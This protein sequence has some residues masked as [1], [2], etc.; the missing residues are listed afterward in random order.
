MI[1]QLIYNAGIALYSAAIALASPFH[2]KAALLRAGRRNTFDYLQ[3]HLQ[4]G[5]KYL[6]FHTASLG[7]FEQGRPVMEALKERHPEARI[8][9]TFFS[10]SGYEIRKNYAGADLV[11][12]LPA[13]T[14]ANAR[15]L[16]DVIPVKA[17]VFIKYEFW[18]NYLTELNRR[19]IPTYSIAAIFR[20]EQVFFKS[21]GKWYRKVLSQFHKIFV[22][23]DA[24]LQLLKKINIAKA[25]IAGDTRFDRVQAVAATARRFP[26]IEEFIGDCRKVIIAGSS[27]PQDEELLVRYL[28]EHSDTKL[29]LVPHEIHENHLDGITKQVPDSRRY[30][31]LK[32]GEFAGI[33][34]LVIDTIGM[35]SSVYQYAS[36]AY[37]GG[38]FGVGIHNTLEAAVWNV[39]V[40]FGPN[41]QKFR[42]ARELIAVGGGFSINGYDALQKC[43]NHLLDEAAG[44]QRSYTIAKNGAGNTANIS[45]SG[46]KAGDYV[47]A[48]TGATSIIINQLTNDIY[49]KTI[50]P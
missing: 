31:Q 17:A 24:S 45:A 8:L 15:R 9:L 28:N 41:N 19:R 43:F 7:E 50:H 10:P 34:C 46:S 20:K 44:I 2:R 1:Q 14:K 11:C 4:P 6:W 42:E 38:G 21:Y 18:V 5:D 12:Y 26:E 49:A 29:I 27:W 47:T 40:V 32:A 23:D 3:Q 30:T 22:Q 16:L 39:P 13:D 33:H 37:I 25:E 36:I 48:N 35:L